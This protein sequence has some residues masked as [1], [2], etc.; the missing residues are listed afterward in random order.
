MT[1]FPEPTPGSE[2]PASGPGAV[3][4]SNSNATVGALQSIFSAMATLTQGFI[5]AAAPAPAPPAA[6]PTP[7]TAPT[8]ASFVPGNAA[9]PAAPPG[10]LSHG[11]WVSGSLYVVVPAGPLTLIAEAEGD[12]QPLWYCITRGH[13]VGITLS[14]AL[15]LAAVTGVPAN[16]MKSYKTQALAVAAF[17]DLLRYHL[18]TVI[19]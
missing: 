3:H 7:A 16:A 13:Y 19:P 14:H 9:P 6:A 5:T 15:A 8:A 4:P 12:E 10:F 18:V 2:A 11:P 1:Q 17:N